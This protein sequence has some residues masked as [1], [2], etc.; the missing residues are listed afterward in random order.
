MKKLFLL[1][2]CFYLHLSVFGQAWSLIWEENFSGNSLDQSVWT[3]E[4]GTGSQN[5]LWGWGNGEL[6]FYQSGN[7]EVSNG[8]LKIIAKEEPAGLT[9][10]W[11]NTMYYSSS[12]IKTDNKFTVKYGKIEARIKTVN[13]EGFWPAFWMLPSGGQWPCDGEIDIMEQ[14]GNDWPTNVT[15]GAAHIGTCPHSQATH[16]YRSFQHQS[17]TGNYASDFHIYSIVWDEDFIAWYV[18]NTKVYQVSPTNFP[19]IPGQHSWPF[20]SNDWY[21]ILNLAITQSGPNSLTVFPSQIEVDYVKVYENTGVLGCKDP[22]AL[23]Y[24]SSATIANGSCEYQVTFKVDMNNVSSSFSVPEV[25]GTFNNWCGNCWPMQ[26]PDGD[27]IWEKQ[28]VMLEGYYELKYSADN[29]A[30]SESLDP[31]WG[32]TNGN[33]QYTNRILVVDENRV[34][35]PQWGMCTPTC[36]SIIISEINERFEPEKTLFPNPSNGIVNFKNNE[37]SKLEVIDVLGKSVY[38]NSLIKNTKYI[39]LSHLPNGFYNCIFSSDKKQ[40]VQ[41]IQLIK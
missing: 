10:S 24:N 30:I 4:L 16:H 32:C 19:T 29:W 38:L 1:L 35:C 17:T 13:G 9:D 8:T 2:S 5:G 18:D 23:N 31:G 3:H 20:N 37:Y 15:T 26:D 11:G 12:R 40:D 39:N 7:A 25:N 41:K 34:I 33:S 22:Q 36:N 14:W 21:L 6:Q 28:V 27:G